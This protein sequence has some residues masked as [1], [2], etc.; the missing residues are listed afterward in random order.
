MKRHLRALILRQRGSHAFPLVI[1]RIEDMSEEE[2]RQW[3]RL[4]QNML[5]DAERN[6]RSDVPCPSPPSL[7]LP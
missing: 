2:A 3:Y 7:R 1:S 6:P 4:L 5:D